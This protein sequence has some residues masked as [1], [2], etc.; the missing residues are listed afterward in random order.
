MCHG[1]RENPWNWWSRKVIRIQ[2]SVQPLPA[3]LEQVTA[4][5]ELCFLL[6]ETRALE[7]KVSWAPMLLG[8]VLTTGRRKKAEM[9]FSHLGMNSRPTMSFPEV[10]TTDL[11]KD[12]MQHW[13]QSD[14]ASADYWVT[15]STGG[16]AG[17]EKTNCICSQHGTDC[18]SE[19]SPFS[20]TWMIG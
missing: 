19:M 5:C 11:I 13:R 17:P 7:K 14:C 3:G 16:P 15:G 18:R 4:L 9:P 6:F 8:L 10:G 12:T 1:V 2:H 20:H